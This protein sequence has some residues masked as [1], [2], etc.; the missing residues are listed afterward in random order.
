MVEDQAHFE[1]LE[2][3]HLELQEKYTKSSDDISQMMEMLKMLTREKQS[4]ETLNPQTTPLKGTNEDIL[5]LQG[6]VLPCETPTTYASPSQPFPFNYGP[7]QFINTLG[8]AI[9]EPKTG[10]DL[11]DPLAVPDLDELLKKGRS[12]Q[13]KV[14]EKYKL[15]EERMRATKGINILGSLDTTE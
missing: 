14:L 11:V 8:L 10:I 1:Q 6:F 7:P 2:K 13:D 3:A 9:C 15:L 5:Y 12:S 4:A